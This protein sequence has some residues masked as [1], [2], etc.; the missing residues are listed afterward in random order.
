MPHGSKQLFN[1]SLHFSDGYEELSGE[2]SPVQPSSP[3]GPV[4]TPPTR[5]EILAVINPDVEYFEGE[6]REEGS[7]FDYTVLEQRRVPQTLDH[8]ISE[9]LDHIHSVDHRLSLH[10][11]ISGAFKSNNPSTKKSSG[12]FF[13][14][15]SHITIMNLWWTQCGRMQDATMVEWIMEQAADIYG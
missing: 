5:E 3:D 1:L 6:G 9:I 2:S 13:S 7:D 8:K 14:E 11:F 4:L 15:N 10:Q 12:R